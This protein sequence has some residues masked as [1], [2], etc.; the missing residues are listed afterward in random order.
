MN[1][2]AGGIPAKARHVVRLGLLV[3]SC[4]VLLLACD[5]NGQRDLNPNYKEPIVWGYLQKVEGSYQ[6][7]F[8]VIDY[9]GLRMVPIVLLNDKRV[10][11]L[12]FSATE[13]DYGDSDVIPTYQK[14][15]LEVLHYWGTGFCHLVMPGDFNLTSPPD[16][17]ILGKESTLVSAWRASRG[18][19]W[20]WVS[21][22]VN[23]DYYDTTGTWDNN[24]F[25]LDTLVY[26]TSISVAPSR[27]FPPFVGEVIDGDGSVTV[28]SGY[29]PADEPGDIGN[30]RGNAVGFVNSINEPPAK[31]FYV[32]APPLTRRA[33][34]GHTVL[35]RLMTRLRA[36]LPSH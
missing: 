26:D 9:D 12:S 3:L 14:Y 36:R 13:Y 25:T 23:Y 33:P 34:D 31:Y 17:Y 7:E 32:G 29:G 22:S 35:E 15:E 1:G 16:L 20:F 24:T 19:Q 30:V 4:V 10:E 21:V 5:D 6:K 27:V 2:H 8:Q 28:F 18:A 11:A